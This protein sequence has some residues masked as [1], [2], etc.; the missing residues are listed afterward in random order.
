M[1]ASA[2][3]ISAP[4]S[5]PGGFCRNEMCICPKEGWAVLED[6]APLLTLLGRAQPQWLRLGKPPAAVVGSAGGDRGSVGS[7]PGGL[8]HVG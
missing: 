8:R 2:W 7:S 6:L 3:R 5:A 1:N 4:L